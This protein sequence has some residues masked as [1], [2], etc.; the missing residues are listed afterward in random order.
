MGR[1]SGS[2]SGNGSGNGIGSGNDNGSGKTNRIFSSFSVI[3]EE[4]E[5][6]TGK[7]MEGIRRVYDT[8]FQYA[9]KKYVPN[10]V[11]SVFYIV[12]Y[13]LFVFILTEYLMR[14]QVTRWLYIGSV[15]M[16]VSMV[17]SG[18]LQLSF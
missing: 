16:I 7:D 12:L 15:V 10:T 9:K 17:Y 2:G 8:G 18:S 1:E 3:T 11:F 5:T 13:T 6:G 4:V 14:G